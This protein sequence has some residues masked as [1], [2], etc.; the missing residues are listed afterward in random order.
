[1][2]RIAP[3]A[4]SPSNPPRGTMFKKLME[5]YGLPDLDA[6]SLP[7]N[8]DFPDLPALPSETEH[9]LCDEDDPTPP[10]REVGD[11]LCSYMSMRQRRMLDALDCM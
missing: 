6:Q 1:M 5:E 10:I 4:E 11:I 7:L 2:S 3:P 9:W 8:Y